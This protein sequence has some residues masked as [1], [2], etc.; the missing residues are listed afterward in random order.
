[1]AIRAPD[2]ANKEA[3]IFF[4][5]QIFASCFCC[6]LVS[7]LHLAIVV[8][9]RQQGGAQIFSEGATNMSLE[10]PEVIVDEEH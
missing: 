7:R 5:W 6:L 8:G 3:T 4:T 9:R 2:G 1:M 10:M